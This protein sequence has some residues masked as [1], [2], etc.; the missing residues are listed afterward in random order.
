[1]GTGTD[2]AM[3]SADVTLVKGDLRGIARARK[4]SRATMGNTKQNLFF[5]FIYN[6]LGVPVGAGHP[7]PILRY[8]AVA[9]DGRRHGAELL[10]GDRQLT[11]AEGGP[12]LVSQSALRH[13]R[14]EVVQLIGGQARSGWRRHAWVMGVVAK[15]LARRGDLVDQQARFRA[16]GD[17]EPLRGEPHR[18]AEVRAGPVQP[19]LVR[20][21]LGRE[22]RDVVRDGPHVVAARQRT[23]GFHHRKHVA[24]KAHGPGIHFGAGGA[25][26]SGFSPRI[27][28]SDVLRMNIEAAGVATRN[29]SAGRTTGEECRQKSSCSKA[30]Q[31]LGPPGESHVHPESRSGGLSP[32]EGEME[33]YNYCVAAAAKALVRT[34]ARTS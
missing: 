27:G 25:V 19:T 2:V 6:T 16:T 23:L 4:L 10:L 11:P 32:T 9:D 13:P 7:L 14:P 21:L 29:T 33:H 20:A 12:D 22:I 5:A 18:N 30:T 28:S 1:M 31:H 8:P 15:F 17:H 3:E 26:L 34:M 24:T